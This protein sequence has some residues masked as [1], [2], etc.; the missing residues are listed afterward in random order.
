MYLKQLTLQ[1][2]PVFKQSN[3][4]WLAITPLK[5]DCEWIERQ[6]K[7]AFALNQKRGGFTKTPPNERL[8]CDIHG[9]AGEWAVALWGNLTIE[10]KKDDET[11]EHLTSGDLEGWIEVKSCGQPWVTHW[12]LI[13]NKIKNFHDNRIYVNTITAL[14]PHYIII[15]GYAWGSIV[16]SKGIQGRSENTQQRHE[17]ITLSKEYLL[18]PRQLIDEIRHRDKLNNTV[19]QHQ[20]EQSYKVRY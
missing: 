15:T 9:V 18:G 11:Y 19:R 2:L 6:G 12:N 3:P 1:N 8:R 10:E 7:K 14:Y 20:F 5:E 16:R 13:V 4:N 17:K